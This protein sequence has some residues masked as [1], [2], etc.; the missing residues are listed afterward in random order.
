ML[1]SECTDPVFKEKWKTHPYPLISRA[2]QNTEAMANL[3]D[4]AAIEIVYADVI[5]Q[6]LPS[7]SVITPCL[8]PEPHNA[9]H[10][11]TFF[12]ALSKSVSLV[13]IGKSPFTAHGNLFRLPCLATAH[14][15]GHEAEL[16]DKRRPRDS[17]ERRVEVLKEFSKQFLALLD[18]DEIIA[19]TEKEK[20]L[21]AAFLLIHETQIKEYTESCILDP[22]TGEDN[23]FTINLAGLFRCSREQKFGF[24]QFQRDYPENFTYRFYAEFA[25]ELVKFRQ[26]LER[27]IFPW[28][29]ERVK[30]KMK[31]EDLFDSDNGLPYDID[32][33]IDESIDLVFWLQDKILRH[34]KPVTVSLKT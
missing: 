23:A 16:F 7:T 15:F 2:I 14:D 27:S 26:N 17:E 10:M 1:T 12:Y 34:L 4:R 29:K 21:H 5:P 32:Q 20:A 11:K 33:A 8:L 24:E 31:A 3:V 13:G 6:E 22:D 9:Y 28:G 25:F 19:P 18:N 30:D